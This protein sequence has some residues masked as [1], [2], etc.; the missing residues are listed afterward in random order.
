MSCPQQHLDGQ[1][2]RRDAKAAEIANRCLVMSFSAFIA[3][4]CVG[5]TYFEQDCLRAHSGAGSGSREASGVRR[6]GT[7]SHFSALDFSA[8][9]S[10][11]VFPHLRTTQRNAAV[12]FS[13]STKFDPA[14]A[15]KILLRLHASLRPCSAICRNRGV[16][17]RFFVRSQSLPSGARVGTPEG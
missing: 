6:S 17:T 9:S 14:L 10:Q 15:A 1:F 13:R 8:S 4:L 7:D 16:C 3:A 11:M 2:K 5:T 12:K